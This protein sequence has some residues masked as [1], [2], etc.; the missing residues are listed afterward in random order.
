MP[1]AHVVKRSV[2]AS[3]LPFS[4]FITLHPYIIHTIMDT[5]SAKSPS[6]LKH[7]PKYLYKIRYIIKLMLMYVFCRKDYRRLATFYPT[8][9]SIPIEYW[10]TAPHN[11]VIS[12][13]ESLCS[14]SAGLNWMLKRTVQMRKCGLK[15]FAIH[16]CLLKKTFKGTYLNFLRLFNHRSRKWSLHQLDKIYIV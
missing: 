13:Q 15:F 14:C 7:I 11:K 3:T 5:K 16:I 9:K 6:M 2:R 12:S 4:L 8:G 10:V 1:L